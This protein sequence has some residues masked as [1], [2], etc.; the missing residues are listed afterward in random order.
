MW[1]LACTQIRLIRNRLYNNINMNWLSYVFS[2]LIAQGAGGIGAI[3]TTSKIPTWYA[4][5]A[6]PSWQPP[7]WVFGP[8]WTTL[9]LLMGIAAA[10]IWNYRGRSSLVKGALI[11]YTVQLILNILWSVVFFGAQSPAGALLLIVALWLAIVATIY[12]FWRIDHTA[13][14]L[15]VPYLLWVTFASVLNATIWHLN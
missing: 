7:S 5:L 6:K 13:A 11:V 3:F 1:N 2:I 15:L 8:V 14:L 9:Y 10:R 4:A 12:Q